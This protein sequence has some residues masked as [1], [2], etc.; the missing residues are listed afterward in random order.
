MIPAWYL[1]AVN[2]QTGEEKVL[3]ESPTERVM[4]I[5]E[6][7]PAAWAIVPQEQGQPRKEYWLYHGQAIPKSGD[8]PPWPP[9]PS[10]WDKGAKSKP[11]VYYDQ[12]D[13]DADGNATLWFRTAEDAAKARSEALGA[14]LRPRRNDRPKISCNFGDLRST[15]WLGRE[16]G[17]SAVPRFWRPAVD[18]VARSGDRA[19]ALRSALRISAARACGRPWRRCRC[20][21]ASRWH[22]TF[23]NGSPRNRLPGFGSRPK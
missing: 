2:L 11:Q 1:V 3:L 20:R 14:G 13:P 8:T 16:T 22:T 12:I 15:R 18:R 9:K 23:P 6:S 5:V 10:P 4:D 17:H 21:W 7:F 19:T